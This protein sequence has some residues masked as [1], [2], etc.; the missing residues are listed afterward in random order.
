MSM[1]GGGGGGGGETQ[2]IVEKSN[3]EPPAVQLPYLEDLY[4]RAQTASNAVSTTP[5]SGNLVAPPTGSQTQA[6]TQGT[7]LAN[8]L[9]GQGYGSEAMNMASATAS[10]QFLMPSSNP[11]LQSTIESALRPVEERFFESTMPAISSAA[12]GAGAF[13]GSDQDMLK[14]QASRDFSREA[15]ATAGNIA[16][17]NYAAERQNQMNSPQLLQSAAQAALT[18]TNM[19][20]QAGAQEQGFAQDQI[21]Q[22]Y[23]QYTMNLL[24]PFIGLPE[25][26]SLLGTGNFSGGSTSK[27][28]T[29]A[30]NNSGGGG[31][32][33]FLQGALGLGSAVAPFFL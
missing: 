5:F 2:T 28:G 15:T 6:L 25:Y 10:G 31:F 33:S 7:N 17:G 27:T 4:K 3:P 12:V 19:L 13:G 11:F 30:S 8:Q 9:Q 24:A 26:A 29:F 1:G 23:Q 14:L 18:P 16:Y 21:D 22:A 32:G 20:Q